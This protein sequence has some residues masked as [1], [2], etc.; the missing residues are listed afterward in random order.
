MAPQV[1]NLQAGKQKHQVDRE[2]RKV[3]LDGLIILNSAV[4]APGPRSRE[5]ERVD[6]AS[7]AEFRIKALCADVVKGSEFGIRHH[8]WPAYQVDAFL[9]DID[10]HGLRHDC[11]GIPFKRH[12]GIY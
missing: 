2:P 5:R 6:A 10:C 3:S 4:E 9:D 8:L 11:P 12:F 1:C 7:T